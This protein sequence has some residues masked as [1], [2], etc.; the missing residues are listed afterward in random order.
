[1]I[2]DQIQLSTDSREQQAE[3]VLDVRGV[4]EQVFFVDDHPCE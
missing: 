1:M 4:H 2:E 3:P